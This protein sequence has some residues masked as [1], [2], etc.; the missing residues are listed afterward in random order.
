[1]NRSDFTPAEVTG[2]TSTAS[3]LE[4]GALTALSYRDQS[5]LWAGCIDATDAIVTG[6]CVAVDMTPYGG[7]YEGVTPRAVWRA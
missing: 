4:K 6:G 7:G 5:I 3:L 1:M 2:S